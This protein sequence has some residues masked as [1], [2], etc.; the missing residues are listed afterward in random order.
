[1]RPGFGKKRMA[2]KLVEKRGQVTLEMTLALACVFLLLMG[3]FKVFF[4]VNQRLVLRQE[5][6]ESRGNNSAEYGRV[7]AGSA[8][9]EVSIPKYGSSERLDIFKESN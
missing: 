7:K 1:M 8:S 6:Y 5:D 3:T 9:E 4:W 2:D